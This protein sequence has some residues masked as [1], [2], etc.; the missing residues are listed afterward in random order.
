MNNQQGKKENISSNSKWTLSKNKAVK[1]VTGKQRKDATAIETQGY[2][3][4]KFMP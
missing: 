3:T 1:T 4:V 2:E